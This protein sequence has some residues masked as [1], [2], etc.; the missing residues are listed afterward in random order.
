MIIFVCKGIPQYPRHPG[1]IGDI[2]DIFCNPLKLQDFL[3]AT[4][5]DIPGDI[6]WDGD[7]SP[8]ARDHRRLSK[9][10]TVRKSRKVIAVLWAIPH[11]REKRS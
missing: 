6:F 4:A 10:E 5:G 2:G 11:Q 7:L 8:L 9:K 1:D 3:Q